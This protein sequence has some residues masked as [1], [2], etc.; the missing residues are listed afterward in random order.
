MNPKLKALCEFLDGLS[1]PASL[2]ELQDQL[3]GLQITA[4][5]VAEFARFSEQSYLRNLVSS[6]E[7]Y[8]LWVMCWKN[9]QRSPI[10]DH[11]GSNCIVQVVRG[12]ATETICELGPNGLVKAA[13]SRDCPPGSFILAHDSD[14][15]QISNLQAGNADLVTLHIYSPPLLRMGTFSL[16]ERAP[17]EDVW[18]EDRRYITSFPENSETPVETVSGWVTPNRLFF[19]RNHFELPEI[20]RR[21]WRLKLHG[22]VEQP[23]EFSLDQLLALP[24]RSVF[25]TMECAGNGRSFLKQPVPGVQWGAGAIGHAEWTGV[26]LCDLLQSAR[27]KPDAREILFEGAD[28]GT[29]ADH[30]DVMHFCRS[31]PLA[32]ALDRHTLLVT[33]MN[34]ELL[35]PNHGA[36]LRLFVPGWYGVASV[37]WLQRIEV[38]NY[39][40]RGYFQNQKYTYQRRTP[41]GPETAIIGPMPVK[42]EIIRPK[43]DSLLGIGMNRIFGVAWA[44]EHSVVKVEVSTSGGRTWEPAEL[45]GPRAPYSWV[46]FEYLWEVA[47]PGEYSILA[48]ATDAAGRVQPR[49]HDPLSGGYQICFSRPRRVRVEATQR[50]VASRADMAALLFDMSDFVEEQS[51]LR[52]DVELEFTLGEGI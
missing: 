50:A 25:C 36:P 41:N 21:A 17:G 31:L 11:R 32:K 15:H 19:V 37:K 42:S 40:Y 35:Q 46:L 14:M 39:A 45:V 5:D 2:F 52:L 34:G 48:R 1:A 20:D 38:I 51:R 22:C 27:L 23:L 9:G 6:G 30:P 29:E 3:K 8:N 43:T 33:R 44:G 16:T 28:Q 10:H 47:E 49:E 18:H 4:D 13:G 12:T 26:P 24:Q 7:H